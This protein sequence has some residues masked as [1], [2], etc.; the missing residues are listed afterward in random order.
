MTSPCRHAE[1]LR[2]RAEKTREETRK[3]LRIH[4]AAAAAAAAAA[5]EFCYKI[6][7]TRRKMLARLRHQSY[8]HV[9][10]PRLLAHG[11]N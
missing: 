1:L 9:Y 3:L 2:H 10:S 11:H 7:E 8:P 4:T 6:K 5:T